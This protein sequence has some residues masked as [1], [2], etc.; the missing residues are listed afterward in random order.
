MLGSLC[1]ILSTIFGSP[2]GPLHRGDEAGSH[3]QHPRVTYTPSTSS[4]PTQ[5][6]SGRDP[7][8]RRKNANHNRVENGRFIS[9]TKS[10]ATTLLST[11]LSHPWPTPAQSALLSSPVRAPD[12]P[13]ELLPELPPEPSPARSRRSVTPLSP[14]RASSRPDSSPEAVEQALE[15]E[16]QFDD[17]LE[18]ELEPEQPTEELTV[19]IPTT[20]NPSSANAQPVVVATQVPSQMPN[21]DMKLVHQRLGDLRRFNDNGDPITEAEY[22]ERFIDIT[23][24]VA[25]DVRAKLW[26]S[27]LAYQGAA[28][29]WYR[30]KSD[31]P[32][33]S[34]NMK[35]WSTL[36][37][38]IEKRW[39]TPVLNKSAYIRATQEAFWNHK[40]NVSDIA[41]SLLNNDTVSM[42][43]QVWSSEHYAKG[44]ACNSTNV[45]RVSYT[46]RHCVDFTVIQ[47][48]PKRHDYDDDF[49]GLCKDMNRDDVDKLIANSFA[50]LA[51]TP[52]VPVATTPS[53]HGYYAYSSPPAQPTTQPLVVSPLVAG[54]TVA[55]HQRPASALPKP[56][57]QTHRTPA[58]PRLQSS[59]D[60]PPHLPALP[61][62]PAT[63]SHTP[64]HAARSGKPAIIL[65]QGPPPV[66]S[67]FIE[68]LRAIQNPNAVMPELVATDSP[69]NHAAYRANVRS[70]NKTTATEA[71][72]SRGRTRLLQGSRDFKQTLDL[73]TFCARGCHPRPTVSG[74]VKRRE[75]AAAGTDLPEHAR[76]Q[77]QAGGKEYSGR[78]TMEH[79]NPGPA[80]EGLQHVDFVDDLGPEEEWEQ[81]DVMSREPKGVGE[82]ERLSRRRPNRPILCRTRVGNRSSIS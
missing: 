80:H 41:D 59:K 48:L 18:T 16:L 26:A 63:P 28:W 62:V 44:M 27:N 60:Q 68:K 53:H 13:F 1:I 61:A 67:E 57:P 73:C 3:L 20:H 81:Y 25:D 30:L 17:D 45:D 50:T 10:T 6:V 69:E 51:V 77:A 55:Q 11:P 66:S 15:D 36:V 2:S 75:C 82:L 9:K 79:A 19:T 52:Q 29:W 5:R 78:C 39:P 70:L 35:N 32:S 56:T 64:V 49:A 72:G 47:L 76:Q 71:L 34:A 38:E 8:R 74:R 12:S 24:G 31:D 33:A 37:L 14:P 23:D 43:H 46:L 21:P 58:T 42:P 40:L 54:T 4:L 65:E 7:T 22:R